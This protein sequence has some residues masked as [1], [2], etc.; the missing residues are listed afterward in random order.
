MAILFNGT[1]PFVQ[2]WYYG[3]HACEIT[4]DLAKYFRGRIL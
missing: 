4:L 2:F 1:E 3:E